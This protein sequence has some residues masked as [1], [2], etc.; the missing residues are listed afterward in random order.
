MTPN[1]AECFPFLS[2]AYT[3]PALSWSVAGSEAGWH[4]AGWARPWRGLRKEQSVQH[5]GTSLRRCRRHLPAAHCALGPAQP[6]FRPP[7]TSVEVVGAAGGRVA[8]AGIKG[9]AFV[10]VCVAAQRVGVVENLH[11]VD[12][13][14][15]GPHDGAGVGGSFGALQAC[16]QR[17]S[18]WGGP[19]AGHD[20][21]YVPAEVGRPAG[22]NRRAPCARVGWL[23]QRK[24]TQAG[25]GR[26]SPIYSGVLDRTGTRRKVQVWFW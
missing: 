3:Q 6:C 16:G 2:A 21:R 5:T 14:A 1:S 26:C 4:E 9:V 19:G 18:G 22:R 24:P 11:A 20:V 13:D 23:A 10:E 8:A 17:M 15:D 12:G 7:R 25:Q